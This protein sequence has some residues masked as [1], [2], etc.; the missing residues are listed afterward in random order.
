MATQWIICKI[1]SWGSH[2]WQGWDLQEENNSQAKHGFKYFAKRK[3][4]LSYKLGMPHNRNV[5]VFI[6]V[7][8]YVCV[9]IDS[10]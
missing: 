6:Y 7:Y 4:N 2:D 1:L 3:S 9:Y 5:D 10:G 8:R